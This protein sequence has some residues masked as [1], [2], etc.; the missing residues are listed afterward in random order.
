VP[1]GEEISTPGPRH[2]N[3]NVCVEGNEPLY[4]FSKRELS[5]REGKREMIEKKKGKKS[6]ERSLEAEGYQPVLI[7]PSSEGRNDADH[8]GGRGGW[9]FL[10][11]RRGG[12]GGE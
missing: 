8:W 7:F 11:F 10:E 1:P 3:G 5:R 2:K 6:W 12:K 4:I 9:S